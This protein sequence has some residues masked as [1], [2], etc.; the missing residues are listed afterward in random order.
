MRPPTDGVDGSLR[1]EMKSPAAGGLKPQAG[2]VM[3]LNMEAPAAA[4]PLRSYH[5][6]RTE[7]S[8]MPQIL[9][10]SVSFRRRDPKG[11]C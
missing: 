1:F 3:V 6:L 4:P 2:Q 5:P 11:V 8:P 9:F 10:I 7:Q